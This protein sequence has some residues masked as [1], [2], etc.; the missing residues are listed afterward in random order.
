MKTTNRADIKSKAIAFRSLIGDKALSKILLDSW[1]AK[2]G[3]S[4][5]KRA[6][7]MLKSIY[8]SSYNYH[9]KNDGRGGMSLNPNAT[10]GSA[11]KN[12]AIM[13]N[14]GVKSPQTSAQ[15]NAAVLGGL[16]GAQQAPVAPTA[17][18]MT[19][20]ALQPTA[21][22]PAMKT[23]FIPGI[24]SIIK[25]KTS[26]E[27]LTAPPT[28]VAPAPGEDIAKTFKGVTEWFKKKNAELKPQAGG[29]NDPVK[30]KNA[31]DA[32][33]VDALL[34]ASD[35]T[36]L[37]LDNERLGGLKRGI[38]SFTGS[39]YYSIPTEIKNQLPGSFPA[40]KIK[41]ELSEY[42]T[43]NP[44]ATS[45]DVWN[46]YK[47]KYN[48]GAP[49]ES[50]SDTKIGATDP[51]KAESQVF[52]E[53][54]WKQ[55]NA[56]SAAMAKKNSEV[57]ARLTGNSDQ[58]LTESDLSGENEFG[59]DDLNT[60]KND[61]GESELD[62]WFSA[63]DPSQQGYY[64]DIY[65]AVKTGVGAE[66]WAFNAMTSPDILK[67]LGLPP[68][69]INGLPKTGLLSTSINDLYSAIKTEFNLNGQLDK[70]TDLQ[71]QGLTIKDDFNSYIRGKDE[72]LNKVDG[73]LT[74][75]KDYVAYTDTSN[76]Y[77][78]QRLSNY[79]NYLTILKGRQN[80]RYIDFVDRS[81][82]EYQADLTQQTNLYKEASANAQE[83]FQKMSSVTEESFNNMKT[84]LKDLYTNIDN[85]TQLARDTEEFQWKRAEAERSEMKDMLDMAKIQKEINS[86]NT[87]VTTAN[88]NTLDGFMLERDKDG[89]ITFLSYDPFEAAESAVR[90]GFDRDTALNYYMQLIGK[91]VK[92]K[93]SY[94]SNFLDEFYKFKPYLTALE[95]YKET[96]PDLY[97]KLSYT[98]EGNLRA[99][100]KSYLLQSEK[101][102]A[103]RDAI[104]DLVGK[105]WGKPQ[106]DKNKFITS[107]ADIGDLANT[108]FDF[109]SAATGLS[110]ESG[111][112]LSVQDMFKGYTSANDKSMANTLSSDLA[113]FLIYND[114]SE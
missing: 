63:L 84:M 85:R 23:K 66:T 39:G 12:A 105:G 78:A 69:V 38:P 28:L 24:D 100:I 87:D 111:T 96:N 11:Q 16:N 71:N 15:K 34:N 37:Q 19:P 76:P 56:E 41:K 81:I 52:T 26:F 48:L 61:Y 25:E 89:N 49:L 67:N 54:Q 86:G 68:E 80:Q 65:N 13:A 59:Y 7:S 53:E 74:K 95:S 62:A 30:M 47:G 73:L 109:A 44:G 107:H 60:F 3:S 46:W 113:Q 8:R 112:N 94:D 33:F 14:V 79:V 35:Y 82:N 18:A 55:A 114:V 93:A 58:P 1:E 103:V 21:V 32:R 110:S 17:P 88:W 90:N 92:D 98:L 40:S 36:L 20:A 50:V 70:I 64:K 72:Y 10:L 29:I 42:K 5:N 51:T 99:G 45:I 108:L 83:K 4:K 22:N 101:I 43:Q 106:K 75:A 77:V 27:M 31:Q 2:P 9:V 91:D 102:I 57:L 97:D 104:D 6:S